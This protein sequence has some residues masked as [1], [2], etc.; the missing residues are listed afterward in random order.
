[1]KRT[2]P[3]VLALCLPFA[4]GCFGGPP[5]G[6]SGDD[7]LDDPECQL[8]TEGEHTPGYPFDMQKYE[9]D[10]LPAVT[11]TCGAA[12]CHAA[13]DGQ[14]SFDVWSDAAIGNCD[15]AR[16]FNALARN[17]D[18]ATPT[19]SAIYVAISGGDPAH[20]V[21]YP[22]GDARRE[23]ILAFVSDASERFLAD[24]GGGDPA[25]PGASPYDY[26][27]FQSDIQPILDTAEDKGCTTSGCHGSGAGGFTLVAAPAANSAD[28]EANFAAVTRR[29][30]LDDPGSSLFYLQATNR[31]GSGNSAVVS[32]AQ[33]TTILGWI[34]DAKA[35]AGNG[36]GDTANCAPID[37]FN[38]GVFRS[39]ILP[40]LSGDI[41]H[42]APGG[43]GT[44]AGCMAGVCHGA[45]RGP[46]ALS[47]IPTADPADLL[48][49]F[50][51]FVDLAAPSSSEILACPLDDPRCRRYPH[52]GQDVFSGPE[53]L[54][55]Q[56]ILAFIYGSKLEASPV[57]FAYFVR[58]VN[59]IFN[60]INAVE[61]GAQGR[62]CSDTVACHG[63]SLAGQPPPNGSDFPIIANAADQARLSY[64]FVAATG[65]INFVD[66]DDSSLF[67]YPTNEIAN[68]ADHPL[69]TGLPHPGGADFAPDSA[70]ASAILEWAAGLR[71]DDDGFVR[72]WLVA[73]DYPATQI[74]DQT[75]V[76]EAAI[77]PAIF[78]SSFG[79]FNNGKWDGL[80]SADQAVDLDQAF[81][82]A[83]TSGRVAYATVYAINTLPTELRVQLQI[84][85]DNPVRIYVGNVLVAQNDAAGGA[86]AIATLPP[87]GGNTGVRLLVK[88]LQRADDPTFS[89]TARTRD[90]LGNLVTR[91][92][93]ELVFVLGPNG[94]I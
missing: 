63:V 55:F 7:D 89:F 26:D 66:P 87:A 17:T 83:A 92:T 72:N 76:N 12:G 73:G 57:D 2:L 74:A 9:S 11:G 16:T 34:E 46:G 71:P 84:A 82:R 47:L 75:L 32:A 45:D 41:D 67:L 79:S 28:M 62:G 80:F 15:Y 33:A 4:A 3:P 64:N 24:G 21:T 61:G 52:P 58:K 70:E 36:G 48:Q 29:G 5:G 93:G 14:G 51:C 19:N 42:N 38:L 86:T 69:A 44:G 25:P 13:P 56:R 59:P 6:G 68:V 53:D 1:M 91:Q 85:S 90:E 43:A 10:V 8:D 81:P 30:N 35:N 20:P 31:H 77:T 65:F 40:I 88:I 37:H 54:N 23:A 39:E 94:G 27:V 60:D 49:Q 18:L 78:D 22:E 50:A